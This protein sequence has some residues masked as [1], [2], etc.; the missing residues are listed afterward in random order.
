[1]L[2]KEIIQ[3]IMRGIKQI[4]QQKSGKINEKVPLKDYAW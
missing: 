4:C 2:H 1:M 3:L